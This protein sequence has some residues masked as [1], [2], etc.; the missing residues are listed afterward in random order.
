MVVRNVCWQHW[1]RQLKVTLGWLNV[2][3]LAQSAPRIMVCTSTSLT[4]VCIVSTSNCKLYVTL[5]VA[6]STSNK[7]KMS[8]EC[9]V[10]QEKWTSLY[11][12]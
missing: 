6:T 8:G 9:H 11:L 4:S 12:F 1:Q 3:I 10:F 5:T 7:H 2:G